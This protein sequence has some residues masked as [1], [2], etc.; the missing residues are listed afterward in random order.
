M[1]TSSRPRIPRAVR[2]QVL[3]RDNHACRYCGATAP[4]AKIVVDHVTPVALG[5]TN[6]P[7]NLVA[8]CQ[9]CNAGKAATPPDAQMVADVSAE[10]LRWARARKFAADQ[11]AEHDEILEHNTKEVFNYCCDWFIDILDLKGPQVG[12]GPNDNCD[13]EHSIRVWLQRGLHPDDI[14]HFI[15]HEVAP[16]SG[17]LVERRIPL[18]NYTA[19]LCWKRIRE[20]DDLT[21][22]IVRSE[23][24]E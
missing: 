14:A 6:D 20:I 22:E 2:Y 21:M 7:T 15:Q 19:S 10:A 9:P 13:P 4:E 23:S 5:G 18:W 1:S 11:L 3:R 24:F 8:A 17:W 12:W 16:R